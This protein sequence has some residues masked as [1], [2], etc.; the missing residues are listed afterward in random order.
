MFKETNVKTN[1]L[2][3]LILIFSITTLLTG[4]TEKDNEVVIEKTVA[5]ADPLK[6]P[7]S[8][9]NKV[10]DTKRKERTRKYKSSILK[11]FK[12]RDLVDTE[13]GAVDE[14]DTFTY[15]LDKNSTNNDYVF[16][17]SKGTDIFKFNLGLMYNNG[18]SFGGL[19]LS[20]N[21]GTDDFEIDIDDDNNMIEVE[22]VVNP[23]EIK[24]LDSGDDTALFKM[25]L[26]IDNKITKKTFMK[27][28]KSILK[29]AYRI[30]KLKTARYRDQKINAYY[31]ERNVY[32]AGRGTSVHRERYIIAVDRAVPMFLNPVFYEKESMRAISSYNPY[33]WTYVTRWTDYRSEILQNSEFTVN[34]GWLY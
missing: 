24:V 11:A 16:N 15:S 34:W 23:N 22:K 6:D 25:A 3:S 32:Y 8:G 13:D 18:N 21:L 5:A 10:S 12:A 28:M 2:M 31:V 29:G 30:K 20:Y 14:G 9:N 19:N 17:G 33:F 4:C 26:D 1:L 27:E 7:K